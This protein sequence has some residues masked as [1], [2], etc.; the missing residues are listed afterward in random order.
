MLKTKKL[1]CIGSTVGGSFVFQNCTYLCK[2]VSQVHIA[3]SENFRTFPWKTPLH[4]KHFLKTTAKEW[5][6]KVKAEDPGMLKQYNKDHDDDASQVGHHDALYLMD[7]IISGHC[8]I[9]PGHV[10]DDLIHA[11]GADSAVPAALDAY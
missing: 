1:I 7:D 4:D 8:V 10:A 3:L 5:T 6:S 11:M 9:H 2:S